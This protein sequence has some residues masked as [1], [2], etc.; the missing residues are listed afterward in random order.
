MIANRTVAL[1][2]RSIALILIAA[3]LVVHLASSE[4][5]L[6]LAF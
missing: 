2:Y 5:N 6:R 3:G 1:I 4:V